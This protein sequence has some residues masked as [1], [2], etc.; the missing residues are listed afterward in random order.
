MRFLKILALVTPA[1]AVALATVGCSS[2]SSTSSSGS[3][4]SPSSSSA[5]AS[6]DKGGGTSEEM[7]ALKPEGMATIKGKVTYEGAP[8]PQAD[9]NIPDN[10]KDKPECLKGEHRDQTWIVDASNKGVQNVVIWIKPPTGKFFDIPAD[11]QKP[12]QATVKIDQPFC[13][14]QP[15][16]AVVFPTFYDAATKKQ[17][18]TGQKLEIVNSASFS[19]NTNWTPGNSLL[20]FGNNVILTAKQAPQEIEAL[21][22]NHTKINQEDLI[23]LKC[24]IHTWMTGY[25]WAFDHP[26]AA[27]TKEDGSYEIK[28]VPAGSKLMLVAWHEPG[29]YY[30]PD[31]PGTNKGTEIG[32]LKDKETKEVNF[33]IS[34]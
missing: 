15:H 34:K 33:K 27:V 6:T 5:V 32:P 29:S 25:I 21:N 24:N 3:S 17:K 14:F 8:P 12:E 19:H 18:R 2:G 26:Y 16:V 13:A 20:D 4:T 7:V 30:S 23:S 1:L 31:G 11:Q 9:I 10:N 22:K 28:N